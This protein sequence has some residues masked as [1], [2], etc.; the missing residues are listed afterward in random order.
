MQNNMTEPFPQNQLF[1]DQ[2]HQ[3]SDA[4]KDV[5]DIQID[6]KQML[7][8]SNVKEFPQVYLT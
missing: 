6:E 3:H 8:T 2:I 1:I 5:V 4:L 7:W